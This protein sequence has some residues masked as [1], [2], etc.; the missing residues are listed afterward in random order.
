MFSFSH[1]ISIKAL[2]EAL[3]RSRCP[4]F[5]REEYCSRCDG[6]YP[7]CPRPDMRPIVYAK[8]ISF[9]VMQFV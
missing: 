2:D 6:F 7:L 9:Y 1:D 4:F 3:E 8:P 5:Y